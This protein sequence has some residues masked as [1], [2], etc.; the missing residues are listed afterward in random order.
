MGWMK[1]REGQASVSGCREK[2]QVWARTELTA[3]AP[4]NEKETGLDGIP[5]PEVIKNSAQQPPPDTH[6]SSSSFFRRMSRLQA[7]RLASRASS[8]SS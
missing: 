1:E 7:G 3:S 8:S 5:T 6:R 2:W 4:W